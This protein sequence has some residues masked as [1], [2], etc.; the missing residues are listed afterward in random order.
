MASLGCILDF[1]AALLNFIIEAYQVQM[2]QSCFPPFEVLTMQLGFWGNFWHDLFRFQFLT[3]TRK[4]IPDPKNS[5]RSAHSIYGFFYMTIVFALSGSMH[6]AGSY[7]ELRKTAPLWLFAGFLVQSVGVAL[8]EMITM[9]LVKL[10]VGPGVKKAVINCYWLS[11]G[12][13][14]A[15]MVIGDM[16]A[17]GLFQSKVIPFGFIDMSW[18]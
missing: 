11:W 8:Q 14:T 2:P 16:A 5:K 1:G 18:K 9:L 4:L 17:C 3:I 15:P 10:K 7:A 6:A 13:L 12:C